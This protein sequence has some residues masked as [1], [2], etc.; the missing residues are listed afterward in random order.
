MNP[1]Q[2]TSIT[3][4][5]S[6]DLEMNQ[7]VVTAKVDETETQKSKPDGYYGDDTDLSNDEL[8]LSFLDDE[9]PADAE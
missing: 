6:E 3:Q 7:P 2:P 4:P 8:D 9:K 1:T 5:N